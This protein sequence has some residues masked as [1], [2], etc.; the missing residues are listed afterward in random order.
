MS[1]TTVRMHEIP[2]TYFVRLVSFSM[3]SVVLRYFTLD[4]LKITKCSIQ[5]QLFSE[6][7]ISIEC[8]QNRKPTHEHSNIITKRLFYICIPFLFRSNIYLCVLRI[9]F[10]FLHVTNASSTLY[11]TRL[12]N[13]Y[14]MSVFD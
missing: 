1:T 8:I 5:H 6:F 7:F 13:A 4:M 9:S 2:Q 3:L 12:K 14:A 10:F 11:K